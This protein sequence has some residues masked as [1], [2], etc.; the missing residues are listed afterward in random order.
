MLYDF[1]TYVNVGLTFYSVYLLKPFILGVAIFKR[2]SSYNYTDPD[3]DELSQLPRT[4]RTVQT[5]FR[6]VYVGSV[7]S[8][9]DKIKVFMDAI[10]W[11][12]T[13][14]VIV[15]S[16]AAGLGFYMVTVLII[17]IELIKAIIFWQGIHC[18]TKETEER[19]RLILTL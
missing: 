14:K 3:V 11:P 1:M 7:L 2:W 19:I 10:R 6:N 4:L 9:Q 12:I 17:S 15:A 8:D 5:I 13:W 16:V 18:V